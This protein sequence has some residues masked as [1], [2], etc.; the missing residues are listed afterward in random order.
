MS[1][2]ATVADGRGVVMCKRLV[3]Q[4]LEPSNL[5]VQVWVEAQ[6]DTSSDRDC[7]PAFT[8]DKRREQ[9]RCTG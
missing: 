2:S 7:A 4:E 9:P 8:V 3:A 6:K 1:S 5:P